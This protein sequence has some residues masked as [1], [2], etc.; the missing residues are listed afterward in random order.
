MVMDGEMTEVRRPFFSIVTATLNSEATVSDTIDSIYSQTCQDFEHI[1]IDGK[2][3]DDTI[4]LVNTH[5]LLRSRVIEQTPAGIYQ[6]FNRGVQAARGQYIG[7]LSSDDIFFD[8]NVLSLYKE[9]ALQTRFKAIYGDLVLTARTDLSKIRRVWKENQE[10]S[11]SILK[12]W[13]P[14][15]PTLYV[16]RDI[17]SL[18]G[19]FDT[20]FKIAGDYDFIIR[21][22][23]TIPPGKIGKINYPAVKMRGGG[24]SSNGFFAFINKATEDY[25]V[26]KKNGYNPNKVLPLKWLRKVPQFLTRGSN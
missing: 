9:R 15:H 13:M 14:P 20:A 23:Q 16:H 11:Q 10:E 12:G 7:F 6:A 17:F 4:N 19:N 8:R 25:R 21:L 24:A 5:S 2:S 18:V 26:L 22:L 3:Y 1:V